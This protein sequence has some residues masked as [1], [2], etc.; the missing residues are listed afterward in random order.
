MKQILLSIIA[1]G[2]IMLLLLLRPV[3][4]AEKK[5]IF[6]APGLTRTWIDGGEWGYM[7]TWY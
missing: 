4:Q 1:I 7:W 3:G 5:C 6:A 2:V